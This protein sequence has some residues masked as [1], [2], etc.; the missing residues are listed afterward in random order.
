LKAE[1]DFKLALKSNPGM[2]ETHEALGQLYQAQRTW[3]LAEV[4]LKKALALK[5]DP[6]YRILLADLYRE[7]GRFT[8]AIAHYQAALKGRPS[9]E[10]L[11]FSLGMAYQGAGRPQEAIEAFQT[12]LLSGYDRPELY[13]RLG[14][15]YLG[16]ERDDEAISAFQEAAHRDPLRPEPY[17]ELG[18]RYAARRENARA[19]DAFQTVLRLDPSNTQ[20][21]RVVEEL[22]AASEE[23]PR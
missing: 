17:L 22:L 8:Q 4:H 19:M 11:L 21:L 7:S 3:D 20:A 15:A 10:N 1:R 14:L 12:A 23:A 18:K 2:P 16:L 6:R 5:P 13:H 9:D